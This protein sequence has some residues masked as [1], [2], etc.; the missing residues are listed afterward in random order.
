MKRLI[1]LV[2]VAALAAAPALAAE[3]NRGEPEITISGGKKGDIA[4]PHAL[5][6]DTL[7]D[8]QVCHKAFPQEKGAIAKLVEEKKL[9]SQE[10]MRSCIACHKQRKKEQLSFGPLS[11][12]DCHQ[13]K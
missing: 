12:K 1:L 2:V 10:V 3:Q 8:C 7:P 9:K 6:Q 13:K 5:H 11:C 4:F